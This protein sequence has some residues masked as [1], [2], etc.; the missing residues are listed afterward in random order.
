M[1]CVHRLLAHARGQEASWAGF[2]EQRLAQQI[3]QEA[4]LQRETALALNML[5]KAWV[6]D[7]VKRGRVLLPAH[8]Q[9]TT[10]AQDLHSKWVGDCA[11]VREARAHSLTAA[12]SET[13][14]SLSERF[15]KLLSVYEEMCESVPRTVE[16][17]LQQLEHWAEEE[18]ARVM[19]NAEQE[20]ETFAALVDSLL[21]EENARLRKEMC[22]EEQKFD[23]G[24]L[25]VCVRPLEGG[26]AGDHT[27]CKSCKQLTPYRAKVNRVF[28]GFG[29]HARR[30]VR[31][32]DQSL[33]MLDH[34]DLVTCSVWRTSSTDASSASRTTYV[35]G[36]NVGWSSMSRSAGPHGEQW[37][38]GERRR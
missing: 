26:A 30:A 29:G 2:R 37:R 24:A 35:A 11:A 14:E 25:R 21:A 6:E 5:G 9:Q 27:F 20:H 22:V 18:R 34:R 17:E 16:E 8:A 32:G 12:N 10:L 13:L 7:I 19:Q 33:P 31:A 3:E 28:R 36:W 15:P 38:T 23:E 4:N 1:P